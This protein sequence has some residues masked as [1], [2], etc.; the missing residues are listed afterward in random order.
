[1]QA[2]PTLLESWTLL[3]RLSLGA[4]ICSLL[5]DMCS[6]YRQAWCTPLKT[7]WGCWGRRTASLRPSLIWQEREF[8]WL[9][10]WKGT[11]EVK[12]FCKRHY[13]RR[14][15]GLNCLQTNWKVRWRRKHHKPCYSSAVKKSVEFPSTFLTSLKGENWTITS[16]C[17]IQESF[18]I[19][20]W[21]FM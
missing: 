16:G 9:L 6:D 8:S 19:P 17:W 10:N 7:K 4:L 21:I 14:A 20:Q 15:E 13:K 11:A 18:I 12:H 2:P 1:M 3:T 5:W